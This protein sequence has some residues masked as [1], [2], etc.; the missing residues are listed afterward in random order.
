MTFKAT[1]KVFPDYAL[2][3]TVSLFVICVFVLFPSTAQAAIGI[4]EMMTNLSHNYPAIARLI[5]AFSYLIGFAFIV[6]AVYKLRAYGE[7]RTMMPSNAQLAGPLARFFIG[8]VLIFFPSFISV[9]LTSLWGNGSIIQYNVTGSSF[10]GVSRAIL[11]LIQLFGYI[12]VIRGLMNLVRGTSQ[13]AQ[14]GT[15]GKGIKYII[16]GVLAINIVGT[17]DVIKASFGFIT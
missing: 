9:A 3:L 14:P 17:I 5:G 1:E 13:G 4:N 2:E 8:V 12:S 11:G 15:V 7:V 10:A 6:S 16:G